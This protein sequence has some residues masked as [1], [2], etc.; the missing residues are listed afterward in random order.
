MKGYATEAGFMGCVG[1]RYV[2]FSCERDYYDYM[3][4]D[5]D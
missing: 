2:L 5:D 1:G 4:E 3:E